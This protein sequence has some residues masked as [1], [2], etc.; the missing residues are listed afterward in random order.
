[1]RTFSGRHNHSKQYFQANG[2]YYL[3][4]ARSTSQSSDCYIDGARNRISVIV[5]VQTKV[6]VNLLTYFCFRT[7]QHILSNT[8]ERSS[9]HLC[10]REPCRMELI[11][12]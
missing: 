12:K 8:F 4:L 7:A 6:S 10:K 2:S 9:D 5:T 1:M 11:N 3:S